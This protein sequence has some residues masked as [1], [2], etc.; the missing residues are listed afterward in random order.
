MFQFGVKHLTIL[1]HNDEARCKVARFIIAD[2]VCAGN[3]NQTDVG[4]VNVV[5][6]RR[7][8]RLRCTPRPIAS[9]HAK[10][11]LLAS[12]PAYERHIASDEAVHASSILYVNSSAAIR[13]QRVTCTVLLCVKIE[14]PSLN[15]MSPVFPIRNF[16]PCAWNSGTRPD[17]LEWLV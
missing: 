12:D 6:E 2:T 4:H 16:G 3:V 10:Q 9:R 1:R 5:W 8:H 15:F 11:R 17:F 7:L 14:S 13:I